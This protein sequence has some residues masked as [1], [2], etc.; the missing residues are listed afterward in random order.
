MAD[1]GSLAEEAR[2]RLRSGA[3]P[4]VVCG[5]LAVRTV[6]WW[7]AAVAVGLAMGIPEQELRRRLHDDPDEMQSPFEDGDEA[8]YGEL[9]EMAGVFDIH[10]QLDA[11]ESAVE[12]RLRAAMGA[13]GG[14]GSGHAHGLLRR[15]AKGELD[16]VL[17]SL[18]R[19]GPRTGRGRPV[20]FW[21]ALVA[22]GELLVEL[23]DGGEARAA[24]AQVLDDCRLKLASC[25]PHGS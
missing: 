6:R 14:L 9:L 23:A 10:R 2:E 5:E 7:D 22:A 11:R 17:R 21:E 20:E 12:K 24:V 4:A 8:L 18:A 25:E 15:F 19:F 3:E 13:M 1:G 16:S